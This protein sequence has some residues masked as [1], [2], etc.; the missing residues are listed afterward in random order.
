[1]RFALRRCKGG[2]VIR[3]CLTCRSHSC[4]G[5]TG[6]INCLREHPTGQSY[7]EG[8]LNPWQLHF[9]LARC[10][11]D[12]A[13]FASC[14]A[15]D[16]QQKDHRLPRLRSAHA[17]QELYEVW[18]PVRDAL[19]A[20]HA[21]WEANGGRPSGQQHKTDH[22]PIPSVPLCKECPQHF[23][24]IAIATA[25]HPCALCPNRYSALTKVDC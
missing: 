22:L 6:R 7:A 24:D 1:M 2:G 21:E 17:V 9:M 14:D 3:G 4:T 8:L 12:G 13:E 15:S 5:G 23:G 16:K 19:E 18:N 11:V 20:I 25:P 10:A